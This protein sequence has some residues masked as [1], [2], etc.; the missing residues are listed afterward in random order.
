MEKAL[1]SQGFGDVND[2]NEAVIAIE[3]PDRPLKERNN[4]EP[5]LRPDPYV[6]GPSQERKEGYR[7]QILKDGR[8]VGIDPEI[9]QPVVFS[10]TD[11]HL[12]TA[13]ESLIVYYGVTGLEL[14]VFGATPSKGM[15]CVISVQFVQDVDLR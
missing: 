13:V 10:V 5:I 12:A 14:S 9:L 4:R 6:T 15:S 3:D 2:V 8:I 7:P 1:A 11:D